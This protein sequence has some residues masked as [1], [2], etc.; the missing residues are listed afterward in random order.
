MVYLDNQNI[1][2][3]QSI[4]KGIILNENGTQNYHCAMILHILKLCYIHGG[5][6][7][8]NG[9]KMKTKNTNND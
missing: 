9:Q 5:R 7:E 8:E 4:S 1:N 3:S 2:Y 6:H